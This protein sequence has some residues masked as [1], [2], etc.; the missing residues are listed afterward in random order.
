MNEQEFE[1]LIAEDRV[2]NRRELSD[3]FETLLPETIPQLTK[4]TLLMGLSAVP[5]AALPEI[6]ALLR[7][8]VTIAK[9]EGVDAVCKFLGELGCPPAL[10]DMVRQHAPGS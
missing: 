3:L 5:K 2:Y 7:R 9:N 10:L 1:A 4:A 8:T 6:S